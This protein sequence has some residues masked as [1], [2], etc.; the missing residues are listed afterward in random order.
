MASALNALLNSKLMALF[1]HNIIYALSRA[2]FLFLANS[3][4]RNAI[5]T[6]LFQTH[7]KYNED[8]LESIE[9]F[10]KTSLSYLLDDPIEKEEAIDSVLYPCLTKTNFYL[11]YRGII[12]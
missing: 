11:F 2:F 10:L 8:V 5:I 3:Q 7:L 9:Q 12:F 6:G 1:S 4:K